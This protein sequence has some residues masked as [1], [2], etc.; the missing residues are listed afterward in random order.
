MKKLFALLLTAALLCSC[1]L[2]QVLPIT[3]TGYA[4]DL[5]DMIYVCTILDG[6]NTALLYG[7]NTVQCSLT[8]ID[9]PA[10]SSTK[11]IDPLTSLLESLFG[12]Y[13][14]DS[15]TVQ[16]NG[17]DA[18]LIREDENE[19]HYLEYFVVLD[20]HILWFDYLYQS[21]SDL[22]LI[23]ALMTSLVLDPT[24]AKGFEPIYYDWEETDSST[25]DLNA[26]ALGVT[27][28]TRTGFTLDLNGFYSFDLTED[29]IA[30]DMVLYLTNE[31]FSL[32][33]AIW[34]YPSGDYTLIDMMMEIMT[35]EAPEENR[36]IDLNGIEAFT[37]STHDDDGTL[38]EYYALDDG[39]IMQVS[40][41]CYT[42]EA[43]AQAQSLMETLL[44]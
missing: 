2:A 12:D 20:T 14:I 11:G 21:E 31:D 33:C 17:H 34:T 10:D 22:P 19:A 25:D 3:D 6:D 9:I 26:H 18:L 29:E 28:I 36:I 4:I 1:A 30:D 7:S 40:F 23:D 13:M 27:A 41:Y 39:I 38:L 15:E 16:L 32:D 43:L 44:R 37:W 35:S 5:G 42:P 24:A 8:V